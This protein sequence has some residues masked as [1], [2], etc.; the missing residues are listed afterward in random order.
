MSFIECALSPVTLSSDGKRY[1]S[2]LSSSPKGVS[3]MVVPTPAPTPTPTDILT[4][5][6]ESLTG[7]EREE[8][9]KYSSI[10]YFGAGVNKIRP[11]KSHAHNFGFDTP[12]GNY[13]CIR[14]DH[15]NYRYEILGELGQG[16]FGDV[17]Q[18]Y[19]HKRRC[20]V[21]IKIARNEPDLSKQAELEIQMLKYVGRHTKSGVVHA[22]RMLDYFS[23]RGHVCI[24]MELLDQDLF[25]ALKQTR[26]SG[27]EPNLIRDIINSVT[28][29]MLMLRE[30]NLV[31]CDLKPENIV[32][33]DETSNN[34]KVIDF[35][36]SCVG[37]KMFHGEVQSRYYR[38]PE[39][40]LETG[41]SFPVDMWSLGCIAAELATGRPLFPGRTEAEQL[42]F[43]MEALGMPSPDLIEAGSRSE[44]FFTEELVPLTVHDS[45]GLAH[46]M[47]SKSLQVLLGEAVDATFLDFISK[48]LVWDPS[49]RMTPEK[50]LQHPYLRGEMIDQ[51]PSAGFSTTSAPLVKSLS[52]HQLTVCTTSI[53]PESSDSGLAR[54]TWL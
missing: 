32:F 47:G 21:A 3:D 31:H 5:F 17:I 42:M 53:S 25:S 8:I 28:Q 27:F 41:F 51:A 15:L 29:C 2:P 36:A 24:V 45:K 50:A 40:I 22:I 20:K 52:S 43:Q 33:C 11:S 14:H 18:A 13:R 1:E 10:F 23:F 4:L 19:D 12:R 44:L 9:K 16:T 30:H 7:F 35:G 46:P 6:P 54:C 34:V 26:F 49:Q 37:N 39:V 48:C 38:A